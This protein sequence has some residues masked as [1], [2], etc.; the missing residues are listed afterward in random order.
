MIP[1][2]WLSYHEE[3][4]KRGYWDM[5]ML[6]HIFEGTLYNPAL[7]YE[8]DNREVDAIPDDIRGAIV[9]LPAR[10]HVDDIP[11]LNK[12]LSRLEWVLLILANDE[13][14]LFSRE[15][16]KHK[17]IVTYVMT[18]RPQ[19][20]SKGNA[21]LFI[22][23]GFPKDA[24][25]HLKAAKEQAM[26]R[27]LDY[28]FSGQ[29]THSRR[30]ELIKAL[31]TVV[32]FEHE[33]NL[34]GE[35]TET[36][37]FTQGFPHNLYYKMMA[38]AKAIPCPSGPATP[39]S[40]RL[41]EA[42]EAGCVPIADNMTPPEL[43]AGVEGYWKYLY[44][45]AP[46]PMIDDYEYLQGKL[47]DVRDNYPMVNNKVFA[48]WQNYKRWLVHR[49]VDDVQKLSGEQRQ[50]K[51]IKSLVTVIVPTSVIPAHPDTSMIEQ[52]IADIRTHLPDSE[53]IISI[54]GIRAEQQDRAA[55]YEEYKR[56]L[57][58]L[59]NHEWLNVLPVVF[60]EHMHQASMAR[61]VLK[62]VKT[63]A[64]LYVEHDAPITPD[65]EIQWTPLIACVT[66]GLAH[67]IRFCHEEL[68]LPDYEHMMLDPDSL[69]VGT[70]QVPMRRTMQWSQRPHLASTAF[71]RNMIDQYFHPDSKTMI[72]D[73]MHG[74]VHSF[75]ER[76]GEQG[77]NL[78]R[79]WIYTPETDSLGI[80]R[81][82]HLDGRGADP[83]FDMDIKPLKRGQKH[84]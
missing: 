81:S 61:E 16:L 2:L 29:I 40:F 3:A 8:Y 51:D 23:E 74:I 45:D 27:P 60:E 33:N 9:V 73:V 15:K 63:P 70:E 36:K 65:R 64:I 12:E 43:G 35:W 22:G 7:G 68:I 19:H 24:R 18:P 82:Y 41:F 57:L 78:W 59:T 72:E 71:Y 55:D 39:D 84:G 21:D 53:I 31:H 1:V 5:G 13:E 83:K 34:V 50:A 67:V 20:D 6:E 79:L 76:E 14:S 11:R 66:Q 37:G 58:W 80:K 4:P 10:Y 47:T 56:R 30:R 75:I 44:P 49:I 52:T 48:W 26:E 28:W 54:D 69:L 17:N 62:L 42:L 77:W 25:E 32:E 38:S 46:F